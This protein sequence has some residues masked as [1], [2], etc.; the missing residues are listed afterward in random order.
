IAQR[1]HRK[2]VRLADGLKRG[3]FVVEP[4]KFFD[5]IT[6]DVGPLQQAVLKSAVDEGINLRRVGETR[7]GI[8]LDERTRPE[9][10]EAVWRAFG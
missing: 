3:G 4:A 10:I 9:T 5:T 7:I 2:T 6:V 8:S 1:I